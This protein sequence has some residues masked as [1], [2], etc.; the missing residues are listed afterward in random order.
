MTLHDDLKNLWDVMPVEA[1]PEDYI[2]IASVGGWI[3][4]GDGTLMGVSDDPL[5][6]LL[7][8]AA[9]EWLIAEGYYVGTEYNRPYGDTPKWYAHFEKIA[10]PTRHETVMADSLPA[11]LAAAVKAVKEWRAE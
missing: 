10:S 11:A 2:S 3:T 8:H 1:R 4:D 6:A 7:C 9:M 5:S